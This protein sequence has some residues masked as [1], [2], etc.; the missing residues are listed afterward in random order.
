MTKCPTTAEIDVDDHSS[1]PYD[2]N[3]VCHK[4]GK[5]YH[6]G[7]IQKFKRHIKETCPNKK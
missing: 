2:P 5:R 6:I 3:L 4:C 1:L 7:E